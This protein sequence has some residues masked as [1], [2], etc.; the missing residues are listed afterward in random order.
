MYKYIYT[1]THQ[2]SENRPVYKLFSF[3]MQRTIEQMLDA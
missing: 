1:H 2:Y 3:S